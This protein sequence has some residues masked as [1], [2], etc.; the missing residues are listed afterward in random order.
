LLQLLFTAVWENN[1]EILIAFS[2]LSGVDC[3]S[4]AVCMMITVSM[5]AMCLVKVLM[6]DLDVRSENN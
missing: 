2:P 3:V 4:D 5:A 1:G 6:C